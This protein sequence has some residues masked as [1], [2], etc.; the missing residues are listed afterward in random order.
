[1]KLWEV[2]NGYI[3]DS[4]VRVL[5][6]AETE[7]RAI[8]LASEKLEE[9]SHYYCRILEKTIYKYPEE[10]WTDLEAEVIFEDL[11]TENIGRVQ[12]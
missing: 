3:A 7:E 5:V 11:A 8:E 9:G 6:V 1:M 4:Y 2:T 12:E 10:Y